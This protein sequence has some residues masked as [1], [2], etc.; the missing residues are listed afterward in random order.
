[1]DSTRFFT[2]SLKTY[3]FS[4]VVKSYQAGHPVIST[5]STPAWLRTSTVS[6]SRA[7]ESSIFPWMSLMNFS[8][9]AAN[10]N[11]SG[12]FFAGDFHPSP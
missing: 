4:N 10:L 8:A 1:M 12:D 7:L 11:V 6:G 2:S 3:G 5:L 9:G